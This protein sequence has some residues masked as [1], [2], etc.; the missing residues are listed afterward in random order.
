MM[1][2][3]SNSFRPLRFGHQLFPGADKDRKADT[4]LIASRTA[5]SQ[6][7]FLHFVITASSYRV[8][9]FFYII[10]HRSFAFKLV[11][12]GE[13]HLQTL[14]ICLDFMRVLPGKEFMSHVIS[15]PNNGSH[16]T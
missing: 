5:T 14:L 11:F 12:S 3:L 9:L 10:S 2:I 8:L 15:I 1:S 7:S 4:P 13:D 6:I 16:R